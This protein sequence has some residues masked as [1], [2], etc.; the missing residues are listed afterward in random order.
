MDWATD[1]NLPIKEYLE[2]EDHPAT[3]I[4]NTKMEP[5]TMKYSNEK[6]E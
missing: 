5:R 3:R 2:L 1:R 6:E 4:A